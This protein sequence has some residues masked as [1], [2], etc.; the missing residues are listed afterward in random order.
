MSKSTKKVSRRR[1]HPGQGD[2]LDVS[3]P[4]HA[5]VR[6]LAKKYAQLRDARMAALVPEVKVR[7]EL[8]SKMH[9]H[10]LDKFEVDGLSVAIV[11]GKEK[12]KVKVLGEDDDDSSDTGE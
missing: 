12:V 2:L 8:L 7:D 9:E 11:S 6:K 4:A 3:H 5:E 10:R 1:Q